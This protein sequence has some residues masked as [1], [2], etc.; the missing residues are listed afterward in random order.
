MSTLAHGKAAAGVLQSTLGMALFG[1]VALLVARPL[2]TVT[3]RRTGRAPL[4][5]GWLDAR[6]LAWLGTTL[7]IRSSLSAAVIM[8]VIGSIVGM[9]SPVIVVGG[10]RVDIGPWRI[11]T[12][13]TAV[14]AA[15]LGLATILLLTRLAPALVTADSRLVDVILVGDRD[16]L[17][18]ELQQTTTSRARLVNGFDLERRRIER[19]LHDGIQPELLGISMTLGIVLA[20]MHDDDPARPLV[21]T[22]QQQSLDTLDHLRRF[23]RGIHPQVLDDHGLAAAL[24]E[25][26]TTLPITVRVDDQLP[27]RL[28]DGTETALYYAIAE[29][30][31]NAAKHARAHECVVTLRTCATSAATTEEP[32]VE[33]TVVDDGQGGA[34]PRGRGLTGVRDRID[35]LGG[36]VDIHSPAGGPTRASITIRPDAAPTTVMP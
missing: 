26:A 35:A 10:D 33:A 7:T 22:A 20:T 21:A 3:L 23:V 34:D 9:L 2:A 8:T 1:A 25:L 19:D 13:P 16:R 5:T 31:T 32:W 12:L 4:F 24:A 36:R 11:T 14:I 17:E 6:S 28:D 30:L 15:S 29:L 27:G 18:A